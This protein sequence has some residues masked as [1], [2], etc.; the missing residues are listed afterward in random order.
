MLRM[1]QVMTLI[2]ALLMFSPYVHAN[3]CLTSFDDALEICRKPL[4]DKDMQILTGSGSSH[5]DH[6][7][8]AERLMIRVQDK[9]IEC[10]TAV[11]KCNRDCRE[12][13][14]L[15]RAGI[16][17]EAAAQ[18]F[19]VYHQACDEGGEVVQYER[20]LEALRVAT[21]NLWQSTGQNVELV[22][23]LESMESQRA[24]AQQPQPEVHIPRVQALPDVLTETTNPYE[25]GNQVDRALEYVK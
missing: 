15:H 22:Q 14:L 13:A 2:G 11:G 6:H 25:Y 1:P 20:A 7:A 5:T 24:P 18:E 9:Y 23:A 12:M 19:D 21:L 17:D 16:G 3:R 10:S 4:S 8:V